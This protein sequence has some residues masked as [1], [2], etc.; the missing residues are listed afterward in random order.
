MPGLVRMG[1]QTRLY[2]LHR[3]SSTSRMAR[4][5]RQNRMNKHNLGRTITMQRSTWRDRLGRL[6]RLTIIARMGIQPRLDSMGSSTRPPRLTRM[7]SLTRLRRLIRCHGWCLGRPNPN[8]GQIILTTLDRLTRTNRLP[9]L[10]RATRLPRQTRMT[11]LGS[12]TSLTRKTILTRS[13]VMTRRTRLARMIILTRRRRL[14]RC[15]GQGYAAPNPN[16]RQ[17]RLTILDRL[18]IVTWAPGLTSLDRQTRNSSM[19]I[20]TR[21]P[22]GGSLG[23]LTGITDETRLAIRTNFRPW[24]LDCID[25]L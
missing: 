2:R 23:S 4:H 9:R 7:V 11:R 15:Q 16:P 1:S 18:T 3:L 8:P 13:E 14:I 19:A 12:I 22:S 25:L 5:T 10:S 6:Y 21:L 20:L 24:M 17:I